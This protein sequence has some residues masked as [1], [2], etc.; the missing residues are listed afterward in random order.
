MGYSKTNKEDD[1]CVKHVQQAT[2][3]PVWFNNLCDGDV[4]PKDS[5][6]FDN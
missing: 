2:I 1:S 5:K 4:M 6:S 3:S